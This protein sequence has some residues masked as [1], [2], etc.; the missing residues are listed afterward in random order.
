MF[1]TENYLIDPHTAVAVNVYQQY[2]QETGDLETPAIIA[3]T[4]SPYKFAA[5]VLEALTGE[6]GQGSE[7]DKVAELSALT[8]TQIPQP[9][10]DLQQKPL[11]FAQVCNIA[12]MEMAVLGTLG[13]Q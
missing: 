8:G 7:F 5:S 13:I 9:I 11:R 2:L 12:G 6:K 1:E 10:A 3:S 4:A